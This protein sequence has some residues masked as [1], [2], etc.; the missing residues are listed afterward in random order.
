LK[1]VRAGGGASANRT[2]AM[3]PVNAMAKAKRLEEIG[4]TNKSP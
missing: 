2:F 1:V 4:K 3:F